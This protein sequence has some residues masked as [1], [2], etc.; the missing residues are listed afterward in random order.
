MNILNQKIFSIVIPTYNS[1]NTLFELC[2]RIKKLFHKLDKSYEIIIIDDYSTDDTSEIINTILKLDPNCFA[3]KLKSNFGQNYAVF[4]GLQYCTGKYIVTI[5]DD[6]QYDPECIIDL[7]NAL[8]NNVDVVIGIPVI[9]RQNLIRNIGSFIFN[10]TN[11]FFN[12][13]EIKCSSFRLFRSSLLE[14]I[15]RLDN[16]NQSISLILLSITKNII[17]IDIKHNNRRYGKS[18]Y[19]LIKLIKLYIN[20][21]KFLYRI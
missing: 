19:S 13:N 7:Y 6:L 20:N 14:K 4:H 21:L 17:N 18:G 5:D 1:Q 2:L 11:Y 10:K 8:D 12:K 9:K 15:I 16:Y 3:V